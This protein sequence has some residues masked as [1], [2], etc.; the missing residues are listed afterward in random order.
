MAGRTQGLAHVDGMDGPAEAKARL[1]AVVR[2]LSG[3]ATI[4]EVAVELGVSAARFHEIRRSALRGAL[5]ALEPRPP[6]RPAG[7][8]GNG[9]VERLEAEVKALKD[10]LEVARI[11]AEI[12]LAMP[13]VVRPPKEGEKGGSTPKRGGRGGT[14]LG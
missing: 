4:E 8:G 2:T 5:E 1:R 7:P 3:E 13:A 11:R 14:W 6:G 12:A 9:E 10:E